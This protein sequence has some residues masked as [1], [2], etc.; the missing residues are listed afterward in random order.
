[1]ILFISAGDGEDAGFDQL[2]KALMG[3][4]HDKQTA[5]DNGPLLVD[6]NI[7]GGKALAGYLLGLAYYLLSLLLH[8]GEDL[9][10]AGVTLF[11]F[12]T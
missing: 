1:M 7:R 12:S 8:A 10:G 5:L 9:L 6:L 4:V 3:F 11:I 2:L